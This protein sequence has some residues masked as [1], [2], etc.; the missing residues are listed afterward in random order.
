MS[1]ETIPIFSQVIASLSIGVNPTRGLTEE[2][3]KLSESGLTP[4]QIAEKI[5][6]DKFFDDGSYPTAK[7]S[8]LGREK[9]HQLIQQLAETRG[10]PLVKIAQPLRVALT[11]RTVSP[12]ID[13]VMEVLGKTE[14]IKR[15][16]KAIEYI[17][18]RFGYL[19]IR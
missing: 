19:N 13:E 8:V 12:P 7:E 9:A 2:I 5:N 1:R 16:H 14:M 11:G 3:K 17:E 18:G 6:P 10:E 4:D 15:L